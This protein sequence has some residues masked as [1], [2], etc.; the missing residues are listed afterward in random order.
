MGISLTLAELKEYFKIWH[1]NNNN[2]D[3]LHNNKFETYI[4]NYLSR[5]GILD[6]INI[7]NSVKTG[8]VQVA[9]I[10]SKSVDG[11]TSLTPSSSLS[12]AINE[13]NNKNI[14]FNDI[15]LKK[16]YNTYIQTHTSQIEEL[17]NNKADKTYVNDLVSNIES[18]L[19]ITPTS[20]AIQN[21]PVNNQTNLNTYKTIGIYK[22]KDAATTQTLSNKPASVEGTAFDLIVLQHMDNGYRQLLLT[23]N[24]DGS[25]NSIY[26]RNYLSSN[27]Q[28]SEW[29]EFYGTH[30]TSPLQMKIEWSESA[31]G[32]SSI[33]T[34]LQK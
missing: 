2:F 34:L 12:D 5:N 11:S 15:N 23:S 26:T 24:N 22:S 28:W 19:G 16:L 33:Y 31:G 4:S 6:K 30:N 1:N 10:I 14:N 8:I 18:D 3:D 9:M 29:Y 27:D 20:I 13:I 32:G 21:M 25:G 7:V 17:K